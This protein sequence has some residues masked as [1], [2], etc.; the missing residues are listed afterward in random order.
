[1]RR[2]GSEI[3]A[4]EATQERAVRFGERTI[5]PEPAAQFGDVILRGGFFATPSSTGIVSTSR[6]VKYRTTNSFYLSFSALDP[7]TRHQ[8]QQSLSRDP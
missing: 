5:E 7:Q 6:R 2:K 1:V 4:D 3:G 8:L